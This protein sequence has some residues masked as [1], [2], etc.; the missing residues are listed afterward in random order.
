[1]GGPFYGERADITGRDILRRLRP[2]AAAVVG[3]LGRVDRRR[4]PQRNPEIPGHVP[5]AIWNPGKTWA[6]PAARDGPPERAPCRA[7]RRPAGIRGG[8]SGI[9]LRADL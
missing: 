5:A 3:A 2:A 4:F 6:A 1:M 8:L 9:L 7:G